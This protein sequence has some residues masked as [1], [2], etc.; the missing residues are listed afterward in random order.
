MFQENTYTCHHPQILPTPSAFPLTGRL[1]S[2]DKEVCIQIFPKMANPSTVKSIKS[3]HSTQISTQPSPSMF[4]SMRPVRSN[5]ILPTCPYRTSPAPL[6]TQSPP[7]LQD[8]LPT[9]STSVHGSRST[10]SSYTWIHY[11]SFRWS[12][13]SWGGTRTTGTGILKGLL[14]ETI[15]WY[16]LHLCLKGEIQIRPTACTTKQRSIH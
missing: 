11:L 2:A 16:I 3:T 15:I 5:S 1:R 7:S 9:T 6:P 4:Q 8:R 10:M 12:P 13:N 14:I